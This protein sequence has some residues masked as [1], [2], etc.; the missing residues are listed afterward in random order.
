MGYSSFAEDDFY[1][2]PYNWLV[3]VKDAGDLDARDLLLAHT[4]EGKVIFA[5]EQGEQYWCMSDERTCRRGIFTRQTFSKHKNALLRQ[6]LLRKYQ[7]PSRSPELS[8]VT[9]RELHQSIKYELVESPSPTAWFYRPRGYL[10]NRWPVWLGHSDLGSRAVLAALLAA[11]KPGCNQTQVT[12]RWSEI[13]AFVTSHFTH[14]S[15]KHMKLLTSG[16]LRK[17][18]QELQL[19][20]VVEEMMGAPLRYTLYLTRF[21]SAPAWSLPLVAEV[22]QLDLA[23][24][25]QWLALLSALMTYCCEPVTRLQ[26][27]WHTL[28]HY[29]ASPYLMDETDLGNLRHYLQLQRRQGPL[30]RHEQVLGGFIQTAAL[31]QPRLCS[32]LF[33]LPVAAIALARTTVAGRPIQ[34][35]ASGGHDVAAT[36]L[37]IQCIRSGNL[38][39][40]EAQQ[41]VGHTRL[42]VWQEGAGQAPVA[43]PLICATPKPSSID[44][45]HLIQANQLHRHIDVARPLEVWLKCDQPDTRLKLHCRFRL[46]LVK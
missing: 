21:A 12:L 11:F 3:D 2:F 17:G 5:D 15:P 41:I 19:L 28:R 30:L 42:I 6:C 44:Y 43:V 27:V 16:K 25:T 4:Y 18:I 39:V 8:A 9:H 37:W 35:P 24:E 10:Q 34:L 29:R 14:S 45:G 7:R 38:T 13:Q 22:C 31:Q 20:G 46:L 36:Q 26:T 23:R 33:E 40:A 32:D 1:R